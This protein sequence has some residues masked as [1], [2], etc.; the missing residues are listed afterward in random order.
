MMTN[1]FHSIQLGQTNCY[2]IKIPDGY[3]MI[4]TSFPAYYSKFL[5]EL[6]RINV[7]ISEIK[8]VLLTHHHDD[9]AGF[10]AVLKEKTGC[11][12]IV[13]KDAV[14]P[15]KNGSIASVNRPLNLR[16]K[17]TM[18][19][20]NKVKRRDFRIPPV[21]LDDGDIIVTGDNDK[22]LRQ[23]G[24]EGRIICTPGH[25]IDSISAI[26]DDGNAFVGDI[27]MNFLNFCGIKYR[28]I[29]LYDQELVFKSWRK[30]IESGANTI[31]PAHGRSFAVDRLIYYEK[32]FTC[33][34]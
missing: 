2:L 24:I 25:T 16:V 21:I 19:I 6:R 14:E 9:H 11:H 31:Y 27:C 5:D 26:L 17:I 30:I 12:I 4:D 32:K 15:L 34:R 22:I 8:Y 20:F 18:T 1:T 33:K 10:A 7:D 3:L 28:P 23:T 29:W 13:H